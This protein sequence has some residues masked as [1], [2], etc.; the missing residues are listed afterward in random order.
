MRKS[1]PLKFRFVQLLIFLLLQIIANTN[2]SLGQ[3]NGYEYVKCDTMTASGFEIALTMK[4]NKTN[5]YEVHYGFISDSLIKKNP[6]LLKVLNNIAPNKEFINISRNDYSLVLN[7]LQ[8][9]IVFEQNSRMLQTLNCDSEFV[10]NSRKVLLNNGSNGIRVTGIESYSLLRKGLRKNKPMLAGHT[11]KCRYLLFSFQ[12]SEV[13]YKEQVNERLFYS[14][15]KKS[16][17]EFNLEFKIKLLP[18]N[19]YK[20]SRNYILFMP[21]DILI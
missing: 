16:N 8:Y 2:Y 1:K 10:F 12:N 21:I 7:S 20:D 11:L 19:E 18:I 13:Y 17:L 3:N 4:N 6:N 15:P 14:Q 9:E 5:I